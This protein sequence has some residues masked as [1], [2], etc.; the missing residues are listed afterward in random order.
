KRLELKQTAENT[1]NPVQRKA[2]ENEMGQLKK[3][4]VDLMAAHNKANP[5]VKPVVE[6]RPAKVAK[7]EVIEDLSQ[8]TPILNLVRT[9]GIKPK[10]QAQKEGKIIAGEY[11]NID[12]IENDVFK[13][14]GEAPDL[15]AQMLANQGLI[16]EPSVDLMFEAIRGEQRAAKA[17][18]DNAKIQGEDNI[19]EFERQK[20]WEQNESEPVTAANLE[21]GDR[22]T[23]QGEKHKV[24]E[25]GDQGLV[26][27]DGTEFVMPYDETLPLGQ[28]R[29][30][31]G[32]IARKN[33][34][35]A[36][37]EEFV[38]DDRPR[39]DGGPFFSQKSK[40]PET[41]SVPIRSGLSELPAKKLTGPAKAL[42]D[43]LDRS[44]PAKEE[45]KFSKKEGDESTYPDTTP[46]GLVKTTGLKPLSEI[47][48]SGNFTPKNKGRN[49]AIDNALEDSVQGRTL[50]LTGG[51]DIQGGFA[52]A[53]DPYHRQWVRRAIADLNL[54][55]LEIPDYL[56]QDPD[57]V[58]LREFGDL[59]GAGIGPYW[60]GI[61][62]NL[63]DE[64]ER[65]LAAADKSPT[66]RTPKF[67]KKEEK[68]K[69]ALSE[70]PRGTDTKLQGTEEQGRGGR[71]QD[72]VG[73]VPG[74]VGRSDQER[75][76]SLEESLQRY[77]GYD[78]AGTLQAVDPEGLS[79]SNKIVR[80]AFDAVLGKKV[81]FFRDTGP[82]G[83]I[84]IN[85]VVLPGDPSTIF[86]DVS[87]EHPGMVVAGHELLHLI[88][89]E[90]PEIYQD[91]LREIGPEV[92]R[93]GTF[94][95]KLD[96]ID[97][98]L[99]IDSAAEELLGDFLGDQMPRDEFWSNLSEKNPTLFQKIADTFRKL[100]NMLR[101]FL[102]RQKGFQSEQFFRDLD[103]ARNA[104]ENA[105]VAYAQARQKARAGTV[106][107]DFLNILED[108]RPAASKK[109]G[110]DESM[111]GF[112]EPRQRNLIRTKGLLPYRLEIKT[113][114]ERDG[115]ERRKAL[116]PENLTEIESRA[117]TRE[118][119]Q[120]SEESDPGRT[121]LLRR[122]LRPSIER[123]LAG[124][125]TPEGIPAFLRGMV[126]RKGLGMFISLKVLHKLADDYERELAA[127]DKSPTARTPKFSKKEEKQPIFYSQ[128]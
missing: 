87:A 80:D 24:L 48:R 104:M 93:F 75:L 22:F 19:A 89:Q 17:L 108:I 122:T 86:I 67:S 73:K 60:K 115:L 15:M 9:R 62:N 123:Y 21:V 46:K 116:G 101:S 91:L 96:R 51:M 105:F 69:D 49:V 1:A 119:M 18:K 110:D 90:H 44:L 50:G 126:D 106:K 3:I 39:A 98:G 38:D 124:G 92:Q 97:P 58:L 82:K 125:G 121:A 74:D 112:G 100:F 47:K 81:V 14:D 72:T 128:V 61:L 66:M 8:H 68:E 102:S 109:E 120:G 54:S 30:D 16:P 85:G 111:V 118:V 25:E 71:V 10:T 95:K 117:F 64:Y 29:V 37:D 65:E 45:P 42:F 84:G 6:K 12:G 88:K 83:G 43:E 13:K 32:S 26:V 52:D 127:A 70:I 57:G 77:H 94:R 63:A 7:G 41:L 78:L 23:I 79:T 99:D 59:F 31:Q 76:R 35:P 5:P 53:T 28:I 11:D 55:P 56:R 113:Q 2:I 40:Q 114:A 103:K 36:Q 34:F 27:K 107:G 4:S 20:H 33:P